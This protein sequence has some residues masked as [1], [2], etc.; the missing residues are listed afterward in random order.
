VATGRAAAAALLDRSGGRAL[1]DES[2]GVRIA[3]GGDA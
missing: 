2:S 1:L 3:P